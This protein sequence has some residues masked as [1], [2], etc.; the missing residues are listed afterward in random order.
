MTAVAG[1]VRRLRGR[2]L[3]PVI[4]RELRQRVRGRG[5]PVVLTVYL[6]ILALVLHQLYVWASSTGVDSNDA[7][8][9][10]TVGRTM[11]HTLL[12]F[13]LVLVWFLVPGLTSGAI[14]GE[15]ERQTLVPLQVTLLGP[16]ALLLGKL[17]ASLV[18]LLLLVAAAMPLISVSFLFGGVSLSEV[19]AGVLVVLVAGVA[20][21]SISLLC[22]TIVK[23]V[24][25]ATVLA[26]F[27]ALTLMLGVFFAYG[28]QLLA[29]RSGPEDS[30][31]ALLV[32]N[33]MMAVADVIR[34]DDGNVFDGD[35]APSPFTP[36]SA[37]LQA[38]EEGGFAGAFDG[39]DDGPA[40][41][42]IPFWAKSVLTYVFMSFFSLLVAA[43][44]LRRPASTEVA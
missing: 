21:A 34:S 39:D 42:L 9:S 27:V 38:K 8:A 28:F 2:P 19:A 30:T 14:A 26:Y 29:T 24:Q 16:W 15:R 43:G 25:G 10:S 37:L 35:D 5:T 11:F 4:S 6:A 36:F 23:R 33:P 7:L 12:F 22:S 13:I 31:L 32:P 3:N 41:P 1:M 17:V 18:F 40:D 20:L 44:R